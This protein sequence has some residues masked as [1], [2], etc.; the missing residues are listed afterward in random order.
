MLLD[1]AAKI[2]ETGEVV[3]HSDVDGVDL[4]FW[5]SDDDESIAHTW[6]EVQDEDEDAGDCA[7]HLVAYTTHQTTTN[8]LTGAN[9]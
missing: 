6:P 4:H 8:T 7:A 5:E 1:D 3:L 9:T 2:H